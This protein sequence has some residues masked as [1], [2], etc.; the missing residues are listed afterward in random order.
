MKALHGSTNA[1]S[2][3][4]VSGEGRRSLPPL[5]PL[6]ARPQPTTLPSKL[7]ASPTASATNTMVPDSSLSPLKRRLPLGAPHATVAHLLTASVANEISESKSPKG[8]YSGIAFSSAGG[9]LGKKGQVAEHPSLPPL[10]QSAPSQS[11]NESSPN[12]KSPDGE[13][14]AATRPYPLTAYWVTPTSSPKA[15]TPTKDKSPAPSPAPKPVPTSRLLWT[16][17]QL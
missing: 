15:P 6:A 4:S 14:T 17:Q 16:A 13:S 12:L 5:P 1:H 2:P 8:V 11:P 10:A 7:L 3:H 9:V